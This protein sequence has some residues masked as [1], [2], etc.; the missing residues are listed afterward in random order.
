MEGEYVDF[1]V[2]ILFSFSVFCLITKNYI[3]CSAVHFQM[4]GKE[5]L[6]ASKISTNSEL[7]ESILNRTK[8]SNFVLKYS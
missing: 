4:L 3:K 6:C 8:Q 5:I 7:S 2:E 1:T